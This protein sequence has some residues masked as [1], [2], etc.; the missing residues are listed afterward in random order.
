MTEDTALA[1]VIT[2]GDIRRYLAANAEATM[3]QALH[4]TTSGALMTRGSVTLAPDMIFR[5]V[6]FAYIMSA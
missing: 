3:Q 5:P 2:D 1:G 4:D 6:S